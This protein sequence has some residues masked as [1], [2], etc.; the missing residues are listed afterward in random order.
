M[1]LSSTN[2][3]M[4]AKTKKSL[5]LGTNYYKSHEGVR[6]RN[7]VGRWGRGMRRAL[8]RTSLTDLLL[9]VRLLRR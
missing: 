6:E 8:G 4:V 7:E 9:T 3:F 5:R 2:V 1:P